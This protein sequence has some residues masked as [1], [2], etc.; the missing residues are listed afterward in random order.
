MTRECQNIDLPPIKHYTI[1]K[2]V[3]NIVEAYIMI[4]LEKD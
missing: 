2:K 1:D 3:D 4:N